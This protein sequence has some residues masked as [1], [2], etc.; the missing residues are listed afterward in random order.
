MLL[1]LKSHFTEIKQ[2]K[3]LWKRQQEMKTDK[4][5]TQWSNGRQEIC[6]VVFTTETTRVGML[7]ER[8]ERP[9]LGT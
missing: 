8:C 2:N 6:M 4:G 5:I 9:E 1:F 3:S 7:I